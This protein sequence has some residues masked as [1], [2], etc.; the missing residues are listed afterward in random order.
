VA[1]PADTA[2]LG[3]Y[4]R[5][6]AV[7]PA[8]FVTGLFKLSEK[9][10]SKPLPTTEGSFVVKVTKK[11]TAQKATFQDVAKRFSKAPSRWSGGDMYWLAKD[12]KAHD[13]KLV[14][15]AFGL[16]KNGISPVIKLNDSTYTFVLMEE[17]K[18]AFTKPFSEVRP[19]IENKL[20]RQEEKALYDQLLKD[21]R[22]R[23]DV[24]IVMKEADFVVEPESLPEL[25]VSPA[26][27]SEPVKQK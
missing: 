19:K 18:E 23:A 3:Y 14:A 17:R 4:A 12:D 20:R 15:A 6:D 16:S 8:E 11:D 24:Q 9:E 27:P 22:A 13:A 21:L 1:R 26:T 25:P 2:R 10:T 7:L 5:L